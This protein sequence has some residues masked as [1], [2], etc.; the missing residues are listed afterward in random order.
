MKTGPCNW[1]EPG[2]YV[3]LAGQ[4][5]LHAFHWLQQ[6]FSRVSPYFQLQNLF[7]SKQIQEFSITAS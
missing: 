5:D 2:K 6:R 4:A 1:H 7:Q 3:L